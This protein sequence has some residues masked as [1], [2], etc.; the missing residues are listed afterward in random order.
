MVSQLGK[1]SLF[2]MAAAAIILSSC[3]RCCWSLRFF[4]FR[5]RCS[6]HTNTPHVTHWQH[7]SHQSHS[8]SSFFSCYHLLCDCFYRLPIVTSCIAFFPSLNIA[9]LCGQ[10][11]Q[12]KL[13]YSKPTQMC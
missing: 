2:H 10:F 12:T 1:T 11:Y 7:Y 6:V 4:I 13:S 8:F 3:R 9:S 5:S